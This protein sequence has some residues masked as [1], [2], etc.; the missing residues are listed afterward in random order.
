MAKY[1]WRVF[2]SI[3]ILVIGVSFSLGMSG[4]HFGYHYSGYSRS[5]EDSTTLLAFS[6]ICLTVVLAILNLKKNFFKL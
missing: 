1:G 4:I 5:V 2:V 3:A 6:F